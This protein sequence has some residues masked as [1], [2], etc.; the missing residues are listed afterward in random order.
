[1]TSPHQSEPVKEEPL[2]TGTKQRNCALS[3]LRSNRCCRND[4]S[5]CLQSCSL[6]ILERCTQ[7]KLTALLSLGFDTCWKRV[8]HERAAFDG[9]TN[10]EMLASQAANRLEYRYQNKHTLYTRGLR[11]PMSDYYARK[12]AATSQVFASKN[13]SVRRL[14][15]R[16]TVHRLAPLLAFVLSRNREP[17][18]R[19]I[20]KFLSLVI[21]ELVNGLERL[22]VVF[23]DG[24]CKTQGAGKVV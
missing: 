17:Y 8:I 5:N 24:I 10:Q 18:G 7:C 20:Q 16:L 23:V 4:M 3:C 2:R 14:T 15:R 6:Q 22:W 21:E 12:Q 19:E 9:C 11:C 13:D 1:M